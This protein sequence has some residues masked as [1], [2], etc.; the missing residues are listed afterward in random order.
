LALRL[1]CYYA[2]Q[3]EDPATALGSIVTG[4][5]LKVTG[6]FEEEESIYQSIG[7]L[8]VEEVKEL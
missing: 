6:E 1:F 3:F 2:L 5:R 4:D 7:T 8:S